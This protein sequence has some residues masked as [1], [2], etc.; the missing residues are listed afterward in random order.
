MNEQEKEALDMAIRVIENLVS[1]LNVL[2]DGINETTKTLNIFNDITL[3][4][5]EKY[6]P[7][8]EDEANILHNLIINCKKGKEEANG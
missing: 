4:I 2:T 8:T 7:I 5:N 6:H 1:K 3:E